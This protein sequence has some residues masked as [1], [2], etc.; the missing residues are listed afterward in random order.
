MILALDA[1]FLNE[2][3]GHL[4]YAKDFS[5][6]RRL[7]DGGDVNMNRLYSV[8]VL[9]SPTGSVADH[10][11]PLAPSQVEAMA[12]AVAA[13]VGVAVG[14]PADRP[15][16]VPEKWFNSLHRGSQG[17]GGRCAVIP[18]DNQ[19][20]VVHALA[21]AINH[22]LGAVGKAVVHTAPAEVEPVNQFE[23]IKALADDM[24]AGSVQ[25]LFVLGGNPLFNAPAELKFREA[26]D[27]VALRVHLG[28]YKRRDRASTATGTFPRRTTSS[29]G[30]T[31]ARSTARR[32][33]SSR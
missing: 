15:A 2:G 21:H 25:V 11:L 10:R 14:G 23:G 9:P 20:A 18:G 16:A 33:S 1:D 32:P 13:A 28:L 6:A 30:A 3:P 5:K 7:R 26:M 31:P 17:S 12:R 27:R 29:R 8:E 19:P 24:A 22:Q 4:R